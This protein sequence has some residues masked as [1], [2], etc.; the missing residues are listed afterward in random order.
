M[1]KRL[2]E[3][4][5]NSPVQVRA[6]LW[7]LVCSFFQKGI[8]VITTPIFTRLLSTE[9]YGQYCVFD[10]WL[11][12]LTVFVTLRLCTS[13]YMQGMIKFESERKEYSSAMQGLTLALVSVWGTIYLIFRDFWNHLFSLTTVQML[14]MFLLMWATAVFGFWSTEQRVNYKYK[15]MVILT[16]LISI[17]KPLIGI[18]FVI[19]AEDKV[20][21]RILGLALVEVIGYT[22]LFLVQMKRGK[23]FFVGK[24]W[25]HAL[26]YNIPLIPHYLSQT[27]LNSADRI[28]IE[29]LVNAKAAGIYGLAYSVSQVM[30]L[31][32]TALGQSLNPWEYRKIRDGEIKDISKIT[33]PTMMIIAGA[34]LLL[35]AFAPELIRIFA[36]DSYY[37]AIWVIPPIAMGGYF[38]YLYERVAKITFYYEHTKIIALTTALSAILNIVLNYIFIPIYGY[39]AA[40]YTTLA[41]YMAFAIFHYAVMKKMC[42][43]H[44]DGQYPYG[45]KVLV[46]IT[47]I[48]MAVT[49][50]YTF[51]YHYIVARYMLTIG[52]VAL[53]IWKRNFVIGSVK[54]VFV[55]KKK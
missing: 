4:Y 37:E 38:I 1:I 17:A 30:M 45:T 49:F 33:Y 15:K 20:T 48:F 54:Q 28:M 25:K 11:N 9:Q 24:F 40:G 18:I 23:R 44:T 14:A 22:G 27:V 10:S 6:T 3:K 2:Y 13:V 47:G 52:L 35:I 26:A 43:R 7:Y 19:L 29:D 5:S 32:N 8:S 12:I 50:L 21:A 34:N 42:R 51:C 46:A 53:L 55:L 36:P 39:Y 16:V 41:C 31:F